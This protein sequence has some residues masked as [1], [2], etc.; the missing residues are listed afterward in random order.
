MPITIE[1][2]QLLDLLEECLPYLE[3]CV[4]GCD[5]DETLGKVEQVLKLAGRE[6][7]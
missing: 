7:E 4:G 2:K 5:V 1:E 6:T 3:F